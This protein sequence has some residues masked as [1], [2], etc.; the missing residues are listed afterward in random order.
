MA[1]RVQ[2]ALAL[3]DEARSGAGGGAVVG[4]DGGPREAELLELYARLIRGEGGQN[5]RRTLSLMPL[6]IS[7]LPAC[8][9]KC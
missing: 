3:L 8:F 6:L 4:E 7:Y 1:G 5:S 2:E 9:W